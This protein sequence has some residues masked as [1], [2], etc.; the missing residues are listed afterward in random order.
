MRDA[1]WYVDRWCQLLTGLLKAEPVPV[2]GLEGVKIKQ[3]CILLPIFVSFEFAC[4]AHRKPP[5][6]TLRHAC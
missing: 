1:A 3:V 6:R 2:E 4:Q 5:P